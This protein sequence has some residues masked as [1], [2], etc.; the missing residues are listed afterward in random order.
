MGMADHT[1][2]RELPS[3]DMSADSTSS[4]CLRPPPSRSRGGAPVVVLDDESRNGRPTSC[5]S[6]QRTAFWN[7]RLPRRAGRRVSVADRPVGREHDHDAR[8]RLEHRRLDV[9]LALQLELRLRRIVMSAPP[10]TI[11]ITS[12]FSSWT[13]AVRQ[14]TTRPSPRA[15][16]NAFS[17]SPA[18]KSGASARTAPPP[19]RA[20]TV[21][22]DVPVV[23]A[24]DLVL[25]RAVAGDVDR[26]C[27][28]IAD[29]AV[30][31]DGRE[32]ARNRVRHGV[33]ERDLGRSSA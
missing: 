25:R 22:E 11:A 32:Q 1:K 5:S 2:T 20:R 9:A 13:G 19:R 23:A 24:D 28:E 29:R 14:K 17:Y 6:G 26:R 16:T 3:A 8:H 12:P 33:P 15:F 21:D 18:A 10:E 4:R 7:A 27:V 30:G 31:V